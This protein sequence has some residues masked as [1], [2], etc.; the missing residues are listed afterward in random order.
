[1]VL[2]KYKEKIKKHFKEVLE[3]K[4]SPRAIAFG[5]A[6]GTA[7]ALLPTFALDVLIGLLIVLIFKKVSKIALFAALAVWN[8]FILV[9]LI[10]VEYAIGNFIVGDIPPMIFKL[11]FLNQVYKYTL[12]YLIGNLIITTVFT[13][14]SYFIIYYVA[15]KYQK[16]K[17]YK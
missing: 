6:L 1:M 15:K 5:F 16:Q 10:G 3:L 4:T 2:K 8:P 13:T 9:P 7:I 17:K 11:E 12:R 14:L